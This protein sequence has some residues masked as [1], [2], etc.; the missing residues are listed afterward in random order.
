[1][2]HP[3]GRREKDGALAEQ[4]GVRL[5]CPTCDAVYEVPRSAIPVG[6][7]DVQ[8]SNC[9]TVWFQKPDEPPA[10]PSG[11]AV[12]RDDPAE[13]ASPRPRPPLSDEG[14]RILKEEAERERELRAG[15]RPGADRMRDAEAAVDTLLDDAVQ[16]RP[17]SGRLA[18]PRPVAGA[19]EATAVVAGTASGDAGD[20]S[21]AT[22]RVSRRDRLPDIADINSTLGGAE[23]QDEENE[24][25][26]TNRG[27][28]FRLGFAA[29]LLLAAVGLVLYVQGPRLAESVPALAEPIGAY[30]SGVNE[31]RIALDGLARQAADALEE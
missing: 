3:A 11:L 18:R 30:R 2:L 17:H 7:R 31:V 26:G 19:G 28:G 16:A 10:P 6:G 23:P 15:E 8:C 24:A 25:N 27:S 22:D 29:A 9:G 21:H 14:R 1:M 4:N 13:A 5:S 20:A 12:D